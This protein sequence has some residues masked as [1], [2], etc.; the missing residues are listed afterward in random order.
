MSNLNQKNTSVAVSTND[1]GTASSFVN[2]TLKG[3]G[4]LSRVREVKP[5]GAQA[6]LA[7]TVNFASGKKE[8]LS[9]SKF[10]LTA[11][12]FLYHFHVFHS[13][14]RKWH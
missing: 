9:Y 8:E 4:Y 1:E 3:S 13:K 6:F 5:R 7:C 11:L 2:L 12:L 10:D 14:G